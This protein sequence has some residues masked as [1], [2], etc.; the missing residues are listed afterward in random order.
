MRGTRLPLESIARGERNLG[1]DEAHYLTAVRRLA[2]GDHFV[3]FDPDAGLEAEARVVI[4]ERGRVV[5]ELDEPSAAQAI[6]GPRVWLVQAVGKGDK[7]DQVARDATELGVDRISPAIA[8]R[9]VAR[10]DSEASL[11]RLRRIVVEASRQCGRGRAPSLDPARPLAEVLPSCDAELRLLLHPGRGRPLGD[12]LEGLA[13]RASVAI[14][15][16]PEGGFDEGE[17]AAAEAAGFE[18][19]HLGPLVLRTETVAAAVLGAIRVL[20]EVR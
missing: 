1:R 17:L 14:A 19:V 9:S 7:L 18:I 6:P 2:E 5:V 12:A 8:E 20:S 13:E 11:A 16:G 10:R 3:A 4:A 15:V